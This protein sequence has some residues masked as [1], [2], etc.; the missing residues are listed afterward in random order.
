M[1]STI[2]IGCEGFIGSRASV[3]LA[4]KGEDIIAIDVPISKG[5]SYYSSQLN[6]HKKIRSIYL[7]SLKDI[8][9]ATIADDV[10]IIYLALQSSHLIDKRNL[11]SGTIPDFLELSALI[12]NIPT[13]KQIHLSFLSSFAVYGQAKGYISENAPID[14]LNPYAFMK[15]QSENML[16]YYSNNL[17][18]DVSVFRLLMCYGPFANKSTFIGKI[19][20]SYKSDNII[21][22]YNKGSQIRDFIYVDDVISALSFPDLPSGF[23]IYN[24][25]ADSSNFKNIVELFE[26]QYKLEG[27]ENNYDVITSNFT[28]FSEVTGWTPTYNIASG[29]ERTKELII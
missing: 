26:V 27:F 24:L 19:I 18:I 21:T 6:N 5:R 25:G 3:Q 10:H 16:L 7:E 2:I 9:W 13:D 23:N 22:L 4:D 17:N 15:Y 11:S 1:P 20:A 28:K 12:E 8:P 29:I 14:L